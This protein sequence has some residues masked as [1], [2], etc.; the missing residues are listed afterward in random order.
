MAEPFKGILNAHALRALLKPPVFPNPKLAIGGD[1]EM[2]EVPLII[3]RDPQL[4]KPAPV[5][6]KVNNVPIE[7]TGFQGEGRQ[8]YAEDMVMDDFDLGDGYHSLI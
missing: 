7:K 5:L 3:Y 8:I 6:E 1:D 4:C 2:S